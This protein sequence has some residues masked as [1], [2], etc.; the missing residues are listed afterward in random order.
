MLTKT[1]K[2]AE[3]LSKQV[4]QD[5]KRD[6][7]HG[8]YKGGEQLSAN[9]LA[10]K[11]EIS[12]TPVREALNSLR[13]E[14]FVDILPRVGYFVTHMTMKDIQ[15][16]FELRIILEGASAELAA[17]NISEQELDNLERINS[18]FTVGD[19]DSYYRYIIDNR[20]FH[21]GIACATGNQWLARSIGMLLDQMQRMV[22]MGLDFGVYT[23]DIIN[24]HPNLLA[25]LRTRDGA[26]ARKVM[27][28]GLETTKQSVL[29]SAMRGAN[30]PIKPPG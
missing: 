30:V 22:Y 29:Q 17:K 23:E 3:L 26:E 15:D 20:A 28:E 9:D 7:L 21:Y 27:V 6:I 13:Q 14:G 24:H 16:L 18:G 2:Y 12:I 8:I 10:E 4:Y 1:S 5:L 25:A 19:L 11:Y